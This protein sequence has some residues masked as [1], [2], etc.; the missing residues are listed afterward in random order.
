MSDALQNFADSLIA[1]NAGQ[2]GQMGGQA[3]FLKNIQARG[4]KA[5]EDRKNERIKT[6]M[7]GALKDMYPD[8]PEAMLQLYADVPSAGVAKLN[9]IKKTDYPTSYDEYVLTT[10]NPTSEGYLNFLDRNKTKPK[11][12]SYVA[13]DGYR[14]YV[15]GKQERVHP[16][17]VV[18]EEQTQEDIFKENAARIKNIVA[19]E[20]ENSPKLTEFER[21]FYNTY[22]KPRSGSII[23][24][25][26]AA[27]FGFG[28]NQTSTPPPST[29][30]P[31]SYK[32]IND[33]Y[34]SLDVESIINATM[35]NN[36]ITRKEAIEALIARDV[37]K[38]K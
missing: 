28:N 7:M 34:K 38:V 16:N 37:I 20:G 21:N 13:K 6:N 25:M 36:D 2:S 8:M 19:L 35:V 29:P 5:E 18:K 23:D 22:I 12:E 24:Q 3:Q 31:T 27:Q 15:D 32:I 1:M 30:P 14:Y 9:Q 10:K 26:V 11:R 4:M 17:V 33:A